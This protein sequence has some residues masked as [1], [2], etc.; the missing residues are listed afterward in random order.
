M[1]FSSDSSPAHAQILLLSAGYLHRSWPI[2]LPKLMKTSVWLNT[3]SN[4]LSATH[5]RARLLGMI[6]GEAI[7]SLVDSEDKRLNFHIDETNSQEGQWYK[8]LTRISDQLGPLEGLGQP[9]PEQPSARKKT[10]PRPVVKPATQPSKQ[11]FIIEELD[12]GSDEDDDLVGYAK[13][14]SDA[15]DSDD[16][17]TLVQRNKPKA[18][19]YIRDLIRHLRDTESYDHQKLALTTAPALIRRKANYGTEVSEHADELASLLVGLQDKFD[20]EDFNELRLQ[21]MIA[22]VVAQPQVMGQWFG[23][24]FFE[25]DYSLSQRA[26]ILMVLGLSARELAGFDISGYETA[27]AFPSK[28]LPGE[29]ERLYLGPPAADNQPSSTSLKALPSNALEGIATSLT[30]AFLAPIAASAADKTS[31]PDVLKLSTFSSR[32]DSYGPKNA[33][34]SRPTPRSRNIPNKTAQQI[35]EYYFSPLTARFRAALHS[36]ASRI[37][38]IIFQPYLLSLY[39][40]TLGILL[41][42][43]G[44]STLALPDMTSELWDILLS[45]SVRAH[46]VGDLDVTRGALFALMTLLEVNHDRLRDIC[47]DMGR[48]VVETQEWVAGVYNGI[49]GGDGDAGEENEAKGLAAAILVRLKEGIDKYQLLLAGDLIGS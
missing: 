40:K 48:E 35:Y 5:H 38:G 10:V 44:P 26:A 49:K 15:E 23:K 47:R 7:S 3:V 31:G 11:G 42:A 17:P 29:L 16:D 21:G 28:R 32:L 22:I 4:R 25:G 43:A 27:A 41:H 39:L 2:K 18:P 9:I 6:V 30:S 45:S 14:D 24:T 8:G 12:D 13:P 46:C 20:I 34:Q 37:R 36:S 33:I 1:R 19:V